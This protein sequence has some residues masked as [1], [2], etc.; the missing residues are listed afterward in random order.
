[1]KF[2]DRNEFA[3]NDINFPRVYNEW[4]GTILNN[5][6]LLSFDYSY[7]SYALSEYEKSNLFKNVKFDFIKCKF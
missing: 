7:F 2:F 1:M 6:L 5:G 4:Y 3:N